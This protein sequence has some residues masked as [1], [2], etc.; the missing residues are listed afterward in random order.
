MSYLK[1][2][3]LSNDNYIEDCNGQVALMTEIVYPFKLSCEVIDWESEEEYNKRGKAL[4][5]TSIEVILEDLV[6]DIRQSIYNKLILQFPEL[7]K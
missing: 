3:Q 6:E 4:S 2:C 7:I 1:L 5:F